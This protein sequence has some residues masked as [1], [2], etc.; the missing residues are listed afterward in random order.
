MCENIAVRIKIQCCSTQN[1]PPQDTP[2]PAT[3]GNNPNT[4]PLAISASTRRLPAPTVRTVLAGHP[5]A[6]LRRRRG[7]LRASPWRWPFSAAFVP[8]RAQRPRSSAS[9]PHAAPGT[10]E[11]THVPECL[12]PLVV[13]CSERISVRGGVV[14][15]RLMPARAP[16]REAMAVSSEGSGRENER[17]S[18]ERATSFAL[19]TS[20]S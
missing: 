16:R 14:K 10:A 2:G 6:A 7:T 12:M 20:C 5:S 11:A 1:Q 9:P 18:P 19:P 15:S 8:A 4:P 17:S 3:P 13:G